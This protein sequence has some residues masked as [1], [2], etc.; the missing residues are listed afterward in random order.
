MFYKLGKKLFEFLV[1]FLKFIQVC[2]IFLSF[3]TIL[4][5]L[6]QLGGATF[7]APVAPFFEGLKEFTHL[8]YT[9]TISV[10]GATIDFSFLIDA[11][12]FLLIVFGLKFIIEDVQIV[13]DKYDSVYSAIKR[14]AEQLFNVGLEQQYI[15][16]EHRNNKFLLYVQ[17]KAVNIAKDSFFHRDVNV[18]VEEK[19]QEVL[20][21]FVKVL[22]E[23][24]QF[25]KRFMGEG[26]LFYF[27]NFNEIDK[28]VLGVDRLIKEQR[29]KH[30]EERWQ[31]ISYMSLEPY[32]DEKEIPEKVK[33]MLSL[34]KLG[35]ADEI[36]ALGTL[37]QRYSLVKNPKC[38]IEGKGVY[39]VQYGEE[40][41][42]CIK[43]LK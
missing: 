34:A 27:P 5:W 32:S 30:L 24:F 33:N 41:V 6:M 15:M 2:L 12:A 38:S 9:R 17:F 23:N 35:D 4:Y 10:D 19:Q 11:F 7:L 43:I 29:K 20:A 42:F 1:N 40:E 16:H 8:F 31:I 39:Q 21:Q 13:E 28:V 18:G 14:K 37:R 26:F 22:G 25:Q 3:A 36:V